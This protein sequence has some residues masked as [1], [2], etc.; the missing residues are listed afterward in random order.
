MRVEIQSYRTVLRVALGLLVFF[1]SQ[2]QFVHADVIGNG[3]VS[4]SMDVNGN[5]VP[6]LPQFGGAVS[7]GDLIVGGTGMQFGGNDFGTVV[8]DIPQDTDPLTASNVTIGGT[9]DGY[10]LIQVVGAGSTLRVQDRLI[11][12]E[13]GQGFLSVF[14]GAQVRTN[15]D[16]NG[17]PS[18]SGSTSNPDMSIGEFEGSQGYVDVD[19]LGSLLRNNVLAVGH[20]GFG[21]LEISN[22]A[23]VQT[24]DEAIIGNEVVSGGSGGSPTLPGNGSV[25]IHGRGTRWNIGPGASTGS[26]GDLTVGNE[27][28]GLLDV[29]DEA[30]VRVVDDAFFGVA[31]DSYGEMT[32]SDQ[33]T[34]V[35]ILDDAQIG[36]ASI[37]TARSDINVENNGTFRVDGTFGV[38]NGGRINLAGGTILT[39]T[40]TNTG[41]MRGDGRIEAAILNAGGDIRTAAGVA[42]IR[43]RMLVTGAVT[44]SGIIESIGGEMEFEALVTNNADGQIF[45]KD[46]I[47]RFRGG[48][49]DNGDTVI[50]NTV[51]EAPILNVGSLTVG[52][53]SSFVLG[54]LAMNSASVLNMGIDDD[55]DH[56]RL[57][58]T[59]DVTLAGR[60][61]LDFDPGYNPAEGDSFE[62]LAASSVTGTFDI[63]PLSNDPNFSFAVVYE[64]DA[65]FISILAGNSALPGDFDG[66]SD[67]DGDDLPLWETGYGTQPGATPGDG[68]ADADGDVDGLDFL[69]WQRVASGGTAANV[70]VN[71]VPE[72][73]SLL[74]G[75]GLLAGL[76]LRRQ[77]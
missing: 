31:A 36:S 66:D 17:S 65:V 20:G 24:D 35:W 58:V 70:A 76:G 19:G 10:G 39:P 15:V 54:D 21:R 38:G 45:G 53:E 46:A 49:T 48:L 74:L 3:D 6:D 18:G 60:L 4:P 5:D 43:E 55:D 77:R 44:N 26:I 71:A 73:S 25:F 12:G 41:V 47:L 11:S 63:E 50:S 13:E 68:D 27:G 28:R 72:P 34:L 1:V 7:G 29:R 8:I 33:G 30:F 42:N 14:A 23:R 67:V 69:T 16:E 59:G 56:S 37:P 22:L 75:L 32:I 51:V 9:F 2:S 62:I 52:P 40:I 57:E 61:T 64:P